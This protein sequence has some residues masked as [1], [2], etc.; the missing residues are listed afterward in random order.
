[1]VTRVQLLL[2]V[3]PVRTEIRLSAIL[4]TASSTRKY[5]LV[6]MVKFT[7]I[8]LHVPCLVLSLK[9]A[10]LMHVPR[11]FSTVTPVI[12]V[13]F[14]AA[15]KPMEPAYPTAP[16]L[17][18]VLARTA[19]VLA[20]TALKTMAPFRAHLSV[21]RNLLKRGQPAILILDT[22]ATT[23]RQSSAMTLRIRPTSSCNAFVSTITTFIALLTRVQCLV[24]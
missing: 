24:L 2:S 9:R 23:A 22:S 8:P 18:K 12:T 14:V 21:L 6:P 4:A 10:P 13:N 7:A 5:V 15:M 19:K 16:V 17:V 1:M 11:H 20:R 3:R